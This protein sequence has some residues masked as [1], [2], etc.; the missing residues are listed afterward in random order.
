M[1]LRR[2]PQLWQ[3]LPAKEQY[4]LEQRPDFVAIGDEI[5]SLTEEIGRT[6][7]EERKRELRACRQELYERRQQLTIAELNKLRKSRSHTVG[8]R[9]PH[10]CEMEDFHRT[11]FARVRHLLDER[12]F[13]ADALFLPAVIRSD[14]GI[15]IVKKLV[16]LCQRDCQL[17]YH[18]SMR[19][20]DDRC[21]ISSCSMPMDR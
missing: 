13:L 14:K 10:P 19:P 1:S 3:S 20:E 9:T 18:P 7:A 5:Q 12:N 8:S 15:E 6:D 2:Q 21:P 4:D 16:S 17:A 11:Y